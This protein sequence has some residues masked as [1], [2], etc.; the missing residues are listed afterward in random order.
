[1]IDPNDADALAGVAMTYLGEY[2][3]GW[4]NPETDYDAKIVGQT[5]PAISL[6]ANNMRA[7]YVKKPIPPSYPP[8][9]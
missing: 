6:D 5:E 3:Y 1:V 8:M 9:E 7:Y 4:T 2:L